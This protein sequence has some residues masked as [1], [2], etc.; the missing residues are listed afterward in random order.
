MGILLTLSLNLSSVDGSSEA[1][2]NIVTT[3][4]SVF[5]SVHRAPSLSAGPFN[6][7]FALLL[8]YAART[9]TMSG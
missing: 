2:K 1:V 4:G 9:C 5:Q 6:F 3:K 8:L 7:Q